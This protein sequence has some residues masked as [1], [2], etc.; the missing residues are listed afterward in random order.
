MADKNQSNPLSRLNPNSMY[1]HVDFKTALASARTSERMHHAWLL[2]GP[3]GI[4]KA[5]MAYIAAAWLLSDATPSDSL[6]GDMPE[7]LLLDLD[8]SGTNQVLNGAHPDF[9]AIYPREEDNKSGQIKIDQIRAMH[10]F[11]M[12]KPGRGK[13]RVAV[14][15]SMDE[16]NRNGANAML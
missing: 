14:I 6:F 12:H 1:G 7:D 4:G 9:M 10:P 5:S 8:D 2:T 15:D 13:M 3:N 11:M 16:I